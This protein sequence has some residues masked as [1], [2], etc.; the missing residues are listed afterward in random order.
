[1]TLFNPTPK[2][3]PYDQIIKEHEEVEQLFKEVIAGDYKK[4]SE[5]R[6]KLVAH[7]DSEE[8]NLYPILEKKEQTHSLTIGSEEDHILARN[9][10][11]ELDADKRDEHWLAKLKVLHTNIQHHVKEE[12]QELLPLAHQT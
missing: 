9:M 1:M 10:I 6:K 2:T 8:K 5:L 3:P 11:K 7:M 4:Y 12:E